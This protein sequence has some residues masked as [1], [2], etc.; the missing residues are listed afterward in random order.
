MKQTGQI[1]ISNLN[2]LNFFFLK[3]IHFN[4]IGDFGASRLGEI[5]HELIGTPLYMSPECVLG[6]SYDAKSDIWSLGICL[7][8]LA[9]GNPPYASMNNKRAMRMIPIV[10]QQ[11]SLL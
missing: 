10:N 1:L 4:L 6:K 11:F 2:V 5:G 9:E 7:I 8:E 3:L